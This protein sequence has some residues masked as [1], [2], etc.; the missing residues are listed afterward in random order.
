MGYIHCCAGLRNSKTYSI[1]PE[2]NYAL[3]Q[4]DYLESCPICGHSVIQLT[5]IDFDNNVSVCRKIN[6]KARRLF[7]KIRNLII[8]EKE[9][10]GL[11]LKA[12]SKFYLYYNEYGIK[13]KCY[14]NLSSLKIGLFENK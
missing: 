3:A 5:R 4:V 8:F 9:P 13:K 14:S 12:Y 6:E 11:R 10:E 2:E 7:D 1:K